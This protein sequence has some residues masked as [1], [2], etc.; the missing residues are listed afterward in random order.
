MSAP[1]ALYTLG[2]TPRPDLVP[3]MAAEL[4]Q[5][6]VQVFGVLD[7]LHPDDIPEPLPGNYPLKTR[8]ENGL[9]IRTD[10]AFLQPRLQALIDQNE[11]THIL[12]IVLS[13]APF[14]S[15]HS[16]GGLLR[17]FEHGCRTLASRHIHEL[18][19]IVPYREQ[20]FHASQKWEYA[21]FSA[22]VLC[23]EDKP[24]DES[25]EA[26]VSGCVQ[27]HPVDG[28]VIDFVGYSKALTQRLEDVLGLPVVDL[29]FE[30][31]RFGGTLAQEFNAIEME[32]ASEKSTPVHVAQSLQKTRMGTS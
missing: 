11:E 14:Q 26:W 21:G 2:Q 10:C 16:E 7:G 15:L 17:P 23:V 31:V 6:D 22:S 29:G 5:P 4:N 12:H 28:V 8:L 1:I 30:A 13:V 20:V 27:S 32:A 3:F 9:E 19:V 18:C 24:D 25:V